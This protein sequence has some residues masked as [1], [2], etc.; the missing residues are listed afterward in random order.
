MVSEVNKAIL[1]V[2]E[3]DNLLYCTTVNFPLFFQCTSYSL[4]LEQG[5]M[6]IDFCQC[7]L[8]KCYFT[9]VSFLGWPIS[10]EGWHLTPWQ[11]LCLR[12]CL[13]S[14]CRAS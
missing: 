11:P 12:L 7:R 13:Y 9:V 6:L 2:R 5:Y 1:C 10:F 3:T 8:L 14:R 4:D